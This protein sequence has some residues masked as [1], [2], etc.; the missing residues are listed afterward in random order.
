MAAEALTLPYASES[1]VSEAELSAVH[2]VIRHTDWDF[3][4]GTD[5]TAVAGGWEQGPRGNAT[6]M[7]KYAHVWKDIWAHTRHRMVRLYKIRAHHQAPTAPHQQF[8]WRN[9][10]AD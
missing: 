8:A 10:L 3:D 1:T 4:I 6:Q 9:Q 5:S 7:G 2:A